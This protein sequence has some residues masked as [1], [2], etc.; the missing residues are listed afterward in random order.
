MA[1]DTLPHMKIL[2]IEDEPDIIAFVKKGL[3]AET[4]IVE[5][6]QT[7][8]KGIA[9]ARDNTYDVIVLDFRLPDMMGNQVSMCIR[10]IKPSVPILVLS[11]EADIDVK[12]NMLQIC[13]D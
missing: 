3:E 4:C 10:A 9:M 1:F 5:S 2:I 6:A 13:D 11:V 8:A 7:G 12:V